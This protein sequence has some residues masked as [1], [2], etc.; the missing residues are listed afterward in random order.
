MND[1]DKE[2]RLVIASRERLL[3]IA[4]IA[5]AAISWRDARQRFR[6]TDDG[7]AKFSRACM[8]LAKAVDAFA[9]SSN[10]IVRPLTLVEALEKSVHAEKK[11][12]KR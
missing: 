11:W 1:A 12:K 3:L 4:E 8:N 10:T 2:M 9:P 5:N 7:S 6:D